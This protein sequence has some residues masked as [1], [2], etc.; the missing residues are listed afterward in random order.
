MRHEAA[1]AVMLVA[2]AGCAGEPRTVFEPVTV[3]VPV[4]TMPEA[5]DRLTGPY[6][7]GEAPRF[8][9]PDDPAAVS[10]LDA[11]NERRLRILLQSMGARIDEWGAWYESHTT[12]P[13]K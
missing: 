10:A 4:P 2:L 12:G 5:P 9:T 11:E 13:Q 3:N 7:F 6:Y 1:A 8:T